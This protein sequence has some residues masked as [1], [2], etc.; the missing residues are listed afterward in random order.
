MVKEKVKIAHNGKVRITQLDN[1]NI[2]YEVKVENSK[3]KETSWCE[4]HHIM[5]ETIK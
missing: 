2:K 5:K 1:L 3:S 4:V